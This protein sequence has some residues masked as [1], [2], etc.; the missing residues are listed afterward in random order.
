[1]AIMIPSVVSPDIKSSAERKIFEWFKK[2]PGTEEWIVLHSLGIT[3]HSRVIY[4]EVDFLVLAPGLGLYALEVKGGRVERKEGIWT[5]TN[6]YDETNTNARGPFEQAC[7]GVFGIVDNVKAKLDTEHQHLKNIF[8]SYGVMF[9]DISYT[10]DGITEQQWQIFDERDGE[11]LEVY[12]KKLFNGSMNRWKDVYGS[13][14]SRELLNREDVSYL[15]NILRGDFEYTLSIRNQIKN[16]ES[17]IIKF[18][19]EQYRCIDQLDDNPRCLIYGPAGTGKTLIAIEEAKKSV[20]EGK[21][22][23]FFCFNNNLAKWIKYYFSKQPQSVQ[24]LFIGTMHKY[25]GHIVNSLG[26]V[27]CSNASLEVVEKYYKEILPGKAVK[28][29]ASRKPLFDK[30]I[31]DEGQDL[32]RDK[33]LQVLDRSLVGGL[34][35]GEW[36]IFGDLSMQAIYADGLFEK[37]LLKLLEN[38]GWFVRFKLTVN[39][40]NTR[41]ICHEIQMVTDFEFS[42]KYIS[43]VD[44]MPVQYLTWSDVEEEKDKLI[45]LLKKLRSENIPLEKITILSPR[46]RKYSVVSKLE[47]DLVE[48]F[49]IPMEVKIS[50]ST[51]QA[52][53][54]LENSVVILADIESFRE[55]KLL[56][57]GL[58]RASSALFVL[59]SEEAKREYDDLFVRRLLKWKIPDENR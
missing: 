6:R 55:E 26:E 5:F 28:L 41:P 38:Y 57:V 29:L 23:A 13:A 20:A 15:L 52:Y 45:S 46:K 18:T 8:F 34:K 40:R 22:V 39:C 10:A 2:A 17:E 56:Y 19:E 42:D 36:T 3:T 43:Q 49:H 48:D 7:E 24:P 53:K 27:D 54:G 1:M 30:I 44:G 12:I 47:E 11:N 4:G 16:S 35:N 50:F 33:Y 32:L 9:P 31:I 51:I 14:E 37:D 59:E 25:M 58:S 21:L